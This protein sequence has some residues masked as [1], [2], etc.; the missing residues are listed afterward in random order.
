MENLNHKET[1][2]TVK[3]QLMGTG[4]SSTM[5]KEL[6]ESEVDINWI[7]V[8]PFL[9]ECARYQKDCPKLKFI[10]PTSFGVLDG[11]NFESK[12]EHLNLLVK[13]G[14]N[15]VTTHSL[16]KLFTP[17]TL[18]NISKHNYN[19]VIDEEL[20]AVSPVALKKATRQSIIDAMVEID[21]EGR[22]IWTGAIPDKDEGQL[23]YVYNHTLTRS[24]T[25]SGKE[26]IIWE[27]SPDFVNSFWSVTVLTYN[28]E[29]T[30][31]DAYLKYHK[32]NVKVEKLTH[33]C[34][35]DLIDIVSTRQMNKVGKAPYALSA[36]KQKR[37]NADVG[38]CATLVKNLT[39]FF[40]HSTYGEA[41]GE[42]RMVSCL[43]SAEGELK[44][45][46]Y[47]TRF[48]PHNLKAVNTLSHV[49]KMAYIYNS[50]LHPD[51]IELFHNRDIEIDR[52]VFALNELL[53]WIYRSQIRNNK[54]I[55]LYIPSSRMRGLLEDWLNE[56]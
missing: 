27:Y 47:A 52:D 29:G 1:I 54:P 48:F 35:K 8:L 5:I 3:D 17:D 21:I 16:L 9:E 22:L 2:I 43:G 11:V 38:A 7:I 56:T 4:K 41:T 19:L 13:G 6:N 26:L 46:G 42:E 39:N 33:P 14:Y 28:F 45:R 50:Y 23:Y 37:F 34:Q 55:S 49:K 32:F 20:A 18:V 12:Q 30:V 25:L 36:S 51:I 10:E 31:F 40:N 53:Q 24:I 44:G 15:I